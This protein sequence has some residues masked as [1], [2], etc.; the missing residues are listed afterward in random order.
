MKKLFGFFFLF[1]LFNASAQ[2]VQANEGS[3]NELFVVDIANYTDVELG[4]WYEIDVISGAGKQYYL[5][6]YGYVCDDY[7]YVPS[8]QMKIRLGVLDKTDHHELILPMGNNAGPLTIDIVQDNA[9]YATLSVWYSA[10]NTNG[11]EEWVLER[12]YLY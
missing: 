4:V 6:P 8:P 9:G 12:F 11:V 10:E 7:D 3:Y 1:V 2:M 5:P